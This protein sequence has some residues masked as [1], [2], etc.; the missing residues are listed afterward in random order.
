[1]GS[2]VTE[3]IYCCGAITEVL[4]CGPAR[5]NRQH[6]FLFL[7]IPGN[8]GVV[9]FYKTFMQTL[10]ASFGYGHPVW[11]V[12]HAGHCQPPLS[13]DMVEDADVEGD[14]FGINGQIEHKLAFLRKHVPTETRLVLLGHSIGCYIILDMMKRNPELQVL[15]AVMLFPT[16]ER[17]AQTPQGRLMTPALSSVE[18]VQMSKSK[19]EEDEYW[20]NSS[21]TKAF[22]FDD[23]DNDYTQLKESKKAVNSITALVDEEEDEDVEKVSWS[24]EPVGSISWSVKETAS[25]LRP[26]GDLR[27]LGFPKISASPSLPKNNSG[28]S[29]SSLFKGKPK[30]GSIQSADSFS[31]MPA[32]HFAPELRKPKSEYKVLSLE[33][34]KSLQD[35]ML[36]LDKAVDSHDGNIITAVLFR[37]LVARETALRHYIHYLKESGE[38]LVLLDLF[39]SLGR[40]ED[41]A[42]L[43]YKHHLTITDENKRRD[44]LKTCLSLPFSP[45]DLA[46]VQDHY[47][48]LERQIIIEENDKQVESSDQSNIF[49]RFPRKASI[50]NMPLITTLYY[51]CIYHYSEPEGTYSSPANI[52]RTFKLAEKQYFLTALGARAK[53]KAWTD[54]DS[55]FTT[56]NW[57]GFTKKKSPVSF[58]RVLDILHKNNAPVHVLEVYVNLLEDVELK[59]NMAHKYKCHDVIINTYRDTKDRQQLLG[60]QRKMDKSTVEHRKIEDVLNNSQIR[61]KN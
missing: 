9:G 17:M 8:P 24:G 1:M 23:E 50:L 42:L 59:I 52:R 7:V 36:L 61:W 55:L 54:V 28:Y 4:K 3:F 41:V 10:Y 46:H 19:A 33:R 2:T 56:R 37:E 47:T 21:Y 58:Q 12:S 11:A 40:T 49:K 51:S 5:L 18:T 38:Q 15:K 57:L 60:Y 53:L 20:N 48:L 16:I 30:V 44:Y 45:E 32:R 34:F 43:K 35:K 29:I 26:A 22:T 39:R 25:S 13:M 14:I 6:K 27:E 31:D